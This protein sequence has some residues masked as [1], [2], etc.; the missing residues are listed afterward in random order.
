MCMDVEK[1]TLFLLGGWD[2]SKELADFWMYHVPSA[3]WNCI[4]DDMTTDVSG[5]ILFFLLMNT[6]IKSFDFP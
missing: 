4:S 6:S 2:G 1:Q 3:Q 5:S